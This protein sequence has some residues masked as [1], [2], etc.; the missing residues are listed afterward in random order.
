MQIMIELPDDITNQFQLQ[1]NNLYTEEDLE[2]NVQAI[3]NQTTLL[4]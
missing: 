1:S 4:L 2:E 3:P